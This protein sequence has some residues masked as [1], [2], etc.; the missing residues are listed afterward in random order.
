MAGYPYAASLGSHAALTAATGSK[1]YAAGYSSQSMR[2]AENAWDS[3][4]DRLK[5][6]SPPQRESWG[7]AMLAADLGC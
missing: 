7:G 3:T 6:D 5:V 4:G 2:G 1:Q